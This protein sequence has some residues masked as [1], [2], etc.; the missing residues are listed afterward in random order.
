MATEGTVIGDAATGASLKK[1]KR[2]A[3]PLADGLATLNEKN[4]RQFMKF[5]METDA[6]ETGGEVLVAY[7]VYLPTSQ[8][9][10]DLEKLTLDHLR[11]LSKNC[12]I[13][14]V[15]NRSK[16]QCRKA[17]QILAS[18]QEQRERDGLIL[19]TATERT[20][21]NIIRL[22]NVIFSNDFFPSLLKL[23][24]IKTRT[25][26][27]TGGMPND[28]WSD[29]A[30]ALN[31]AD[32]DDDDDDTAINIIMDETDPHFDEMQELDLEDFDNT[33]G[34]ASRKKFNVLMKVMKVM[35]KNMTTSGEHDNDA[36]NFVDVAMK[37]VAGA[38]GLSTIGCYYFF[39]RCASKEHEGLDDAF[40][41]SMDTALMGS[42][43]QPSSDTATETAAN[44]P[45][46]S[47]GGSANKK[48]AF[49]AIIDMS[50]VVNSIGEQMK[51]ATI[52]L[53]RQC[54]V[55]TEK[56]CVMERQCELDNMRMKMERENQMIML[57][58]HLND[59]DTL[60]KL[61]ATLT[62]TSS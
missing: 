36:Y 10:F 43:N 34:P 31:T 12:G 50:N 42:T 54:E 62:A 13:N 41:D 55:D 4:F 14:Y 44:T 32:D 30:D 26:H 49:A 8:E 37:K 46:T 6:S 52:V 35:K 3:K 1:P 33:T 9:V 47:D 19:S 59:D 53:E 2:K 11:K 38:S 39:K 48:R 57:A 15:N 17:L 58:K 22:V 27:E 29:V 28:F 40:V 20:S 24:D 56:K 18:F 21:S 23:N 7:E 16:F 5:R 45:A 25:D 51:K 61:L 60:R